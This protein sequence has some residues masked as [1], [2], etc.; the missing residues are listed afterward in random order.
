MDDDGGSQFKNDVTT[1]MAKNDA[2]ILNIVIPEFTSRKN[3][4]LS[5]S[6]NL[7]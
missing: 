7:S 3:R 4:D 5:R 6:Y 1:E 2:I